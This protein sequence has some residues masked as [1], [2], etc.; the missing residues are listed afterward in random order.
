MIIAGVVALIGMRGSQLQQSVAVLEGTTRPAD[1]ASGATMLDASGANISVLEQALQIASSG[2]LPAGYA[3]ANLLPLTIVVQDGIRAAGLGERWRLAIYASAAANA[4]PALELG[5]FSTFCG[6]LPNP[7]FPQDPANKWAWC[8][9]GEGCS[10]G[11]SPY[12]GG[13]EK[14]RASQQCCLA[15]YNFT[16]K[17]YYSHVRSDDYAPARV[18]GPD[19]AGW[20]GICKYSC[21]AGEVEVGDG[22]GDICPGRTWG[23]LEKNWV[24]CRPA[25]R[26]SVF[27]PAGLDAVT[28][29]L[30]YASPE[31]SIVG[32]LELWL[33]E[34]E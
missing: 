19:K 9:S 29:P 33:G 4:S 17:A 25:E 27:E 34:P 32:R 3:R 6:E 8:E 12:A 11:K 30:I 18:C 15:L 7:E 31:Q 23:F 13:Q 5:T 10:G 20:R 26:L 24:C 14:C 28:V 21:A 16:E 1:F 22:A 2:R